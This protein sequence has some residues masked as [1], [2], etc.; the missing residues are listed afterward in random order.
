MKKLMLFSA[1]LFCLSALQAQNVGVGTTNPEHKLHVVGGDIFVQSSS[2]SLRFGYNGADQWKF[3]TTGGGAHFRMQSST[4][5]T[6][7]T[8]LHYFDQNGDVGFGI[9][10]DDP[11]KARLDIK[12]SS[13]SSSTNALM[14]RNLDGDTMM[15]VRNNGYVGIGYNGNS[16]GRPLNVQGTGMNFYYNA[17]TFGGAVF[18]DADN[19]LVLWSN[20]AGP[21]QNVVLQPSWGQVTI[22]TYTPAAG[23]KVSINGKLIC[24]EA[25]V[26]LSG[27]WPDYVFSK[28][29]KLPN[30]NELEK[31]IRKNNH[32]PNMPSAAEVEKQK[33]FDLG[34]MQKRLLEKVEELTLYVIQLKKENEQL[35][36]RI[37]AVEKNK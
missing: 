31:Y 27:S 33:G 10:T 6:T 3:P 29:Y 19:N 16:Y 21:G 20:N 22:G 11:P 13:N 37:E 26:Q 15:R 35:Q 8:S 28:N 17:T 12:S 32:L 24:E 18:P 34:D 36:K 23:Y 9:G 25:R 14:L 1:F 2:G 5:G 30:I 4:N 7:F